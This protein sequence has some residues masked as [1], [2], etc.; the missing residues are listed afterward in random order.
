MVLDSGDPAVSLTLA[1]MEFKLFSERLIV[2]KNRYLNQWR[3]PSDDE[4]QGEA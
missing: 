1:I 4:D 3:I 2:R